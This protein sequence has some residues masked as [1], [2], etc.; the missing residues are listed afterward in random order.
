MSSEVLEFA[1]CVVLKKNFEDPN[2]D[3]DWS[4]NAS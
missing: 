2:G 1:K 3:P 4:K